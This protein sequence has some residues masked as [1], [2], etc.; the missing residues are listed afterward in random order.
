MCQRRMVCR[1][2][3]KGIELALTL[4][5][6]EGEFK[7]CR[8]SAE[9]TLPPAALAAD[10]FS[11]T[12]TDDELSVVVGVS[13]EF[14][15]DSVETGWAMFKL[16]GPFAFDLTGIVA[17]IS[18]VIAAANIGIFVISTYDTD[19]ILIKQNNLAT[20]TTALISAGYKLI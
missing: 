11:I 20:A 13:A 8:F 1:I 19:Y 12:K 7:I 14:P 9:S 15:C 2:A 3:R 16:L 10:W 4:K 18:K 17:G 6:L 5:L